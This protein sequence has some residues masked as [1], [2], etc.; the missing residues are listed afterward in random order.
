[1]ETRFLFEL[2]QEVSGPEKHKFA[3]YLF[4]RDARK[5]IKIIDFIFFGISGLGL[6]GFAGWRSSPIG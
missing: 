5:I 3:I 6:D 4:F 1:M 2:G